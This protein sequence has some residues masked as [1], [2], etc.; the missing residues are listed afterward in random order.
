MHRVQFAA[1]VEKVKIQSFDYSK[2]LG[3]YIFLKED[4]SCYPLHFS[5]NRL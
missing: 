4:P 1:K 5:Q 3:I 2:T